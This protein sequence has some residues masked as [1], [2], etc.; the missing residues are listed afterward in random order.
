ME[1]IGE[2]KVMISGAPAQYGRTS[3]GVQTYTT[4]AGTNN[5]HGGVF[6]LFHN[7][8]LDANTWFNNLNNKPTPSDMKNEYGVLLGGPVWIPHLYDGH[9]RTFFFFSSGS[10][11]RLWAIRTSSPFLHRRT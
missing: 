3:G 2:F 10:T 5:W 8:V 6:D 11:G 9:N 4:K 1:A 7:T